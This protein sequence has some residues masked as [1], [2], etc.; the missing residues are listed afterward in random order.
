MINHLWRCFSACS[1]FLLLT[2]CTVSAT[3][4]NL[5]RL[6]RWQIADYVDFDDRQDAYFRAELDRLLYWHRVSELPVY[7]NRLDQLVVEI[8]QELTEQMLEAMIQ[9]VTTWAERIEAQAMS[10][11]IELMLSLTDAQFAEL[12]ANLEKA[13]AE[14]AEDELD[15]ELSEVRENWADSMED[16][17]KYFMGSLT[18]EQQDY[19]KLQSLRYQP[20]Q[21]LWVDYRRRWQAALLEALAGRNEA[22]AFEARYRKLVKERESFWSPEFTS[23][24]KSNDALRRDVTLMLLRTANDQ[25]R[26]R[27]TE[28]LSGFS[29]DFRELTA[30][31]QIPRPPGGGCLVRCPVSGESS[32]IRSD[33]PGSSSNQASR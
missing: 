26:K 23:V 22:T 32:Q 17:A 20:E 33:S 2:G 1:L 13:N 10:M 8:N 31:A 18:R 9:D 7:A 15:I 11:T 16:G 27:M 4:N 30:E 29:E 25:Q 19:V 6:A 14:F 28:R 24:S 12:P 21:V 3:Y 5:D